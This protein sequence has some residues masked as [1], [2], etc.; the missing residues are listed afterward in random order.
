MIS[1]KSEYRNLL[2][3]GSGSAPAT[4]EL[5]STV[6]VGSRIDLTGEGSD[7]VAYRQLKELVDEPSSSDTRKDKSKLDFKQISR[8]MRAGAKKIS[9]TRICNTRVNSYDELIEYR[10]R[11]EDSD[12]DSFRFNL[13]DAEK[14]F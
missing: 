12:D 9:K 7:E 13:D 10:P 4:L 11:L 6:G 14:E 8:G 2:S 1:S 5:D 3:E